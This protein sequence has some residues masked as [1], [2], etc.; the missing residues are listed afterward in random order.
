MRAGTNSSFSKASRLPNDRSNGLWKLDQR[1]KITLDTWISNADLHVRFRH[2][3][4]TG[5][6][7]ATFSKDSPH[8][9]ERVESL[10]F[11]QQMDEINHRAIEMAFNQINIVA[12]RSFVHWQFWF[13]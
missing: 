4:R 2:N 12:V 7:F 3:L 13:S 6:Q 9:I 8:G 11:P 10:S 5:I 1:P